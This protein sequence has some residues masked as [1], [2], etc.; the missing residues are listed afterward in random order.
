MPTPLDAAA[1]RRWPSRA[2]QA[3]LGLAVGA[4]FLWLAVRETAP[5]DALRAITAAEPGW[6]AA[7]IALYAADLALRAVRWRGLLDH[8]AA[9]PYARF[10]RALIVG[11]GINFLLPARLG[12]IFRIEFLKRSCDVRRSWGLIS[13][14]LERLLDGVAVMACLGIG[15]ALGEATGSGTVL[16]TLLLSGGALLLGL[17]G[18]LAAANWIARGGW[19]RRWT[20]LQ[21]RAD[22]FRAALAIAGTWGFARAALLTLGIYAIEALTLACVLLALGA[23]PSVAEALTVVGA[24]SLSTLLPSA[25]G[26]IGSYQFAF[27]LALAQFGHDAA[28]GV[29]AATLVQGLL[30]APLAVAALAIL[31][32]DPMRRRSPAL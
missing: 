9:P 21:E 3:V 5:E 4:L 19:V 15:I 17:S 18:A 25:P 11:Y 29:A 10:A 27:T 16:A 28:I 12:E 13:V 26:F 6:L 7:A 32:M 23:P 14:A 24:A 22:A 8:L 31:S 30:F 2:V 20:F 1:T